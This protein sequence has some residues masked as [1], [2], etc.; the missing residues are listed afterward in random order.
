[1][2][3]K[4]TTRILELS[5]IQAIK[6]VYENVTM[7]PK[8]TA[9]QLQTVIF[10][11]DG[12]LLHIITTNAFPDRLQEL[13]TKLE[14]QGYKH[15]LY[16]TDQE[17]INVCYQRYDQAAN[18][19]QQVDNQHQAEQ[20]ATGINAVDMLTQ[21][22]DKRSTYDPGDFV[23]ELVR[24]S[25]QAGWSDLHFQPEEDGVHMKVRIDGVLTDTL[26]F[27]H[28][29][30]FPFLQK[31]KFIA[32][33]K[34]NIDYV[35]QD[36]R[37]SFDVNI[38]G[39]QRTI[40]VRASFMPWLQSESTVLR[41]LD[42]EKSIQTFENIWFWGEN[43]TI[44]KKNIQ[45]NFGMILVTWPTW[46]GKTTTLYSILNTLNDG[47]RK[48]ITLEDPIEYK[49]HGI[50]QSQINYTKEYDYETWLKACLRHDPDVLLVGETRTAE[51]ADISIN[52]ALTWH[53]VFTTLH[54]NSAI[55]AISRMLNMGVK[56][57]VFAPALVMI[58]AQRLVRK[59]CPHCTSKRDA[60]YGE[61]EQ[62]K[63]VLE[64]INNIHPDI[65]SSFDG[66]I[67][68][69]VWCEQ[70]HGTGYQGRIA[71][72][73]TLEVTEDIKQ[74]IIAGDNAITIFG[75]ARKNGFITLQEDGFLK[76]LKWMTTIEELRR[77]M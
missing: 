20:N 3:N 77:V 26:F 33:T 10:D 38:Q 44:L 8:E 19:K 46:S 61:S 47:Q 27:T 56:S 66:K 9:E 30:F 75:L 63:Q 7:I 22:F 76:M 24:L 39:K 40:D 67:P 55:E 53:L 6:P 36:G 74:A 68:N 28:Q 65:G 48:I 49:V 57:Y 72:I 71:I 5:H 52:A 13:L 14:Q 41:Y 29:E 34:M 4:L 11:N 54:T 23:M 51:T 50:Q 18:I 43:Y 58:V 12:I 16:Y 35:P 60:N 25:F 21:L 17:S 69:V 1:M 37:F 45:K 62:V 70:C 32:W 42:G 59:V 73:E 64:K 2:Q 31:M 15:E